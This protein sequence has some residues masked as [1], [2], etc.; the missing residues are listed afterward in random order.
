M[1]SMGVLTLPYADEVN[2]LWKESVRR[3]YTQRLMHCHVRKGN[4]QREAANDFLP[5]TRC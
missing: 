4:L 2:S 3:G 5:H 1:Q